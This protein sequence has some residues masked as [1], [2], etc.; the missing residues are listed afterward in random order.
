MSAA[1]AVVGDIGGTHARFALATRQD[2]GPPMLS[3]A[4]KART[5]DHVTLE[6]AYRHY[7]AGLGVEP[8]RRACLAVATAVDEEIRFTN[9]PWTFRQSAL[10]ANLALDR[11][12]IINDFGAV[13]RAIPLLEADQLLALREP[14][15]PLPRSGVISVVGPGTGLGVAMIVH[16]PDGHH[17]V[18]E[19]EG[20]HMSFAPVDALEAAVA[21]RLLTRF[22]RVSVERLVSGPGLGLLREGMAAI[23]GQPIVP[24]DDKTLWS[25]AIDGSDAFARAALERFCALFGTACGDY[26]L[27]QGAGAMVIAGGLAPRFLDILRKSAFLSRFQA[28]GRFEAYMARIPIYVCLHPDPGLLGAASLLMA[29]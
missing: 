2:G 19:T 23:E 29:P 5:A 10:K 6:A 16:G 25:C 17:H 15:V 22:M 20:G 7:V 18:V 26:A 24:L 12:D 27:A 9:N 11:L 4:V 8:P 3:H 28:K 13:A 14:A 21:Q 1:R